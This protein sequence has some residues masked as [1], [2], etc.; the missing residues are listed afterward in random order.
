VSTENLTSTDPGEPGVVANLFT[1]D[2]FLPLW[3]LVAKAVELPDLDGDQQ[4]LMVI[5]YLAGEQR[6]PR[7]AIL[8]G[9]SAA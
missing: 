7:G 3:I 8:L 6:A 2:R 4:A 1:L 5:E 9:C